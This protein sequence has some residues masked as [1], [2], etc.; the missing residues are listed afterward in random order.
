[1]VR[2]FLII[3]LLSFITI[4]AQ[5]LKWHKLLNCSSGMILSTDLKVQSDGNNAYV[6]VYNAFED[7]YYY[8][9]TLLGKS[10]YLI[11]VDNASGA[12][13]WYLA[14][15]AYNNECSFDID[16]ANNVYVGY[17]DKNYSSNSHINKYDSTASLIWSKD[18]GK[19]SS[20]PRINDIAYCEFDSSIVITGSAYLN[21]G[22]YFD[23]LY[24]KSTINTSSS[25]RQ[26]FITKFTNDGDVSWV[27]HAG[28]T[29]GG[30]VYGSTIEQDDFGNSYVLTHFDISQSGSSLTINNAGTYS[31]ASISSGAYNLIIRYAK[32]GKPSWICGAAFASQINNVH[33]GITNLTAN[34]NGDL[35]F[36]VM[37][38]TSSTSTT[39][40][41]WQTGSSKTYNT[42][43]CIASIDSNGVFQYIHELSQGPASY[44]NMGLETDKNGF[45]YELA[46]QSSNSILY[47]EQLD[48]MLVQVDSLQVVQSA[49]SFA[50]YSNGA[51]FAIDDSGNVYYWGSVT[52]NEAFYFSNDSVIIP[53]SPSYWAILFELESTGLPVVTTIP[54]LLEDNAELKLYPNPVND[55]LNIVIPLTMEKISIQIYDLNGKLI[56][57]SIAMNGNCRITGLE[58]VLLCSGTYIVR[59]VTPQTCLSSKLVKM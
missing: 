44:Y 22:I 23:T 36:D 12:L 56:Y 54:V 50:N 24:Y 52:S 8:D 21:A 17:V 27:N 35:I 28:L 33:T 10:S 11:K 42:I 40:S 39:I 7:D 20:Y 14:V 46:Y 45:I 32:N 47:I 31:Y 4:R 51:N 13:V 57:T 18:I 34:R 30:Q 26:M 43:G 37:G 48:S 55:E 38:F 2:F 3:L 49:L 29:K 19:S 58:D 41:I 1:M 53:P 9:T 5:D 59:V 15:D 25:T 6:L 16:Q